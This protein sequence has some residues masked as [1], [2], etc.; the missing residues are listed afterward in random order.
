MTTSAIVTMLIGM[1]AIWGGLAA[2]IAVAVR[3]SRQKA[4]EA[5]RPD[6]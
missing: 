3:R 4:A 5:P 1:V 6:L 2:S